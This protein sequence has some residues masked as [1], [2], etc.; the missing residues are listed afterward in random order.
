MTDVK[1]TTAPTCATVYLR[2][3]SDRDGTGLAVSR[4][5]EDALELAARRG[6]QVLAVHEDNDTSAAGKR[7][8][9]GFDAALADVQQGRASVVVA[10]ALDRLTRNARDRIRLVE[11]CRDA[12]ATVA[13][14]RGSDMDMSTP[15][16]RLV[17]GVLGEVAQAE[18]DTKSDRQARA[19]QQAAE[20]GRRVGGRR[21]FG[22]E[23]DGVT[24]RERE[25]AAVREG[26]GLLLAGASLSGI[27]ARWNAAALASGQGSPWRRDSVRAVLANPRNA[28]LRAL[29][30]V[31][32]VGADGAP[33]RA[34]WPALVPE[35]TWRA[36]VD[37]FADPQRRTAPRSARALLTG[38]ALCGTC[39]VTIHGGGGARR[40]FRN[41]R[42]P[43]GAHFSRMAEPVED[44][45]GRLVVARLA[46]EDAAD[47]LADTDRPDAG[48][49]RT[50]ASALRVRLDALAVDYAD[51]VLT[52]EQVRA[53]TARLR[54]HLSDVE[55][56]MA[57]AGRVSVLGPLV[58]AEDV[59]AA[60]A[61]MDADRQRAVVG[62]L[63]VVT[64]HAPGR[65]VRTFRPESVGITWRT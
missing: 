9:P 27:A 41:Y 34:V 23:A 6:W 63:M 52:R 24:V 28:G 53:A 14:V 5:R 49:L 2:Q 29:R 11:V 12:G 30:R 65:G 33:V 45:V 18:I 46:R 32:V 21:P 3:S 7:A 51:G 20:A 16:G 47:L 10:W 50:E 25:A 56:R 8:R 57:D 19:Q 59:R 37:M 17:A 64:V 13:L 61:G 62:A 22:Y 26:Y 40:G 58:G 39:G 4:Q 48:Q 44:Y 60:W 43:S 38:L 35:E 42:C 31:L 54:E 1:P 15:A 36:A 55:A